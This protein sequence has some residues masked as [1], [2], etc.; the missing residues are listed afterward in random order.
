[1][2]NLD[3]ALIR[4]ILIL[5][6]DA[7]PKRGNPWGLAASHGYSEEQILGHVAYLGETQHINGGYQQALGGNFLRGKAKITEKGI[8]F[9]E[10]DGGLAALTAPV[11]RIAPE[12]FTALIDAAIAASSIPAKERS[13]I[14][15]ILETAEAET[16]KT[17]VQKLI[18]AG[19]SNIGTIP[20]LL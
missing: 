16:I 19:L 18:S 13:R 9:L 6:K 4:D 20:N 7:Y 1:M 10:P 2:E 17:V 15:K 12:S 14:R 5:L 8:N 11:I 3:Y